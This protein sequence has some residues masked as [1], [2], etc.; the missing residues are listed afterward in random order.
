ME[1]LSNNSPLKRIKGKEYFHPTRCFAR[2]IHPHTHFRLCS[3]AGFRLCSSA[4]PTLSGCTPHTFGFAQVKALVLSRRGR[5]KL[6]R[7]TSWE[8]EGKWRGVIPG[9]SSMTI[10]DSLVLHSPT[11]KTRG[12]LPFG[13]FSN[14]FRCFLVI[15]LTVN[16]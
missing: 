11:C 13:F 10:P 9:N 8:G 5:G 6:G 12:T 4:G 14:Y 15:G 16:F 7:A 3:S 2:G 1:L